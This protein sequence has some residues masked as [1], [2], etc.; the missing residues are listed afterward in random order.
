MI[1]RGTNNQPLQ[2]YY[3]T[4]KETG[5]PR[6]WPHTALGG[7]DKTSHYPCKENFDVSS[8]E[9]PIW[10]LAYLGLKPHAVMQFKQGK[11][12]WR[13]D[14]VSGLNNIN[15]A[16]MIA[17]RTTRCTMIDIHGMDKLIAEDHKCKADGGKPDY[18]ILPWESLGEVVKVM[19]FAITP[20]KGYKRGSWAFV[21][22]GR[23]R[24]L[25]AAF[26]HLLALMMGERYDKETNIHHGAHLVCCGLFIIHY[27]KYGENYS[28]D[29]QTH[30]EYNHKDNNTGKH[31]GNT[32]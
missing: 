3:Y 5:H 1:R 23:F 8:N 32:Q 6:V 9:C 29:E 28:A 25:K 27:D 20:A 30:S 12:V 13:W 7:T 15:D 14:E 2:G 19:E 11:Y 22:N 24:Y 17:P 4:T 10:I 21:S 16:G 31:G 18:T 26:R